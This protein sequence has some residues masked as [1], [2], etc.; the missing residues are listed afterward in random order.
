M[1][2]LDPDVAAAVFGLEACASPEPVEWP[3]GSAW[4]LETTD[5]PV[6]ITRS[7]EGTPH[8]DARAAAAIEL[9][10][11]KRGVPVEEALRAELPPG[12]LVGELRPRGRALPRMGGG[13]FLP[14]VGG[15]AEAVRCH[16]WSG[17]EPI[18]RH[19]PPDWFAE[20]VGRVLAAL[21]ADAGPP[22]PHGRRPVRTHRRVEPARVLVVDGEPLLVAWDD[23]GP[24]TAEE[25]VEAAVA[26]WAA[27]GRDAPDP[28]IGRALLRGYEQAGGTVDRAHLPGWI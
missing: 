12:E 19:A 28:D 26:V 16:W 1:T 9:E 5:G 27:H 25:E 10:A 15:P 23:A 11:A 20:A 18:G 21:H 17:G 6:R 14:E 3:V 8:A 7:P 2:G 13:W 4:R 24:W 22:G